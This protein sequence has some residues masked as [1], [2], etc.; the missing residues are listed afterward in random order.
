MFTK[1]ETCRQLELKTKKKTSCF[2]IF[3]VAPCMLL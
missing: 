2:V 1:A 3:I